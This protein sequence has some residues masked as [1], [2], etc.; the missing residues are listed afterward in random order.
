[1]L[2]SFGKGSEEKGG[3]NGRDVLGDSWRNNQDQNNYFSVHLC[4]I[5]W[6]KKLIWEFSK[7]HQV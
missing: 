7:K 1:M 5:L 2:G 3:S 4:Q 6:A